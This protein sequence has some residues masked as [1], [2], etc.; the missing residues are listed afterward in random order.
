MDE[1]G[2]TQ[3]SRIA[4]REVDKLV[5]ASRSQVNARPLNV[6]CVDCGEPLSTE[7]RQAAPFAERCVG[8]QSKREARKKR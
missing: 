1:S 6:E 2:F 5:S 4:Q 7:R 8:C 3:A